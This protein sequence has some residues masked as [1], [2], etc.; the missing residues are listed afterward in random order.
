MQQ[1]IALGPARRFDEAV[2]FR[3]IEPLDET[4]NLKRY[5]AQAVRASY[6]HVHP[7]APYY[8]QEIIIISP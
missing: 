8:E 4:R 7:N 1:D 6:T 5:L 2:A 3:E